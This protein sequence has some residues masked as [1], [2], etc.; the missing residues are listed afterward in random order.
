MLDDRA[1]SVKSVQDSGDTLQKNLEARERQ[2]IQNQIAQLDKRWDELNSKAQDR[3]KTLEDIV[4]V[5][6]TFQEIRDPLAAWL[7]QSEKKFASLEP[8]AMDADGIENIITSLEDLENDVKGKDDQIKTL[9]SV[10][11]E[12]Q[13]HCKGWLQMNLVLQ[14]EGLL[15]LQKILTHVCLHRQRRLT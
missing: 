8:T 15:H 7:D 3:S 5:A 10:G 9:A 11:K 12:L 13:N 6:Q 2:A 1:P 14:K 4:E